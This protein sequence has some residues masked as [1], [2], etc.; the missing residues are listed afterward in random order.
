M[1]DADMSSINSLK[2]NMNDYFEPEIFNYFQ[3]LNYLDL[4]FEEYNMEIF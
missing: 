4:Y 3:N 1:Q 2:I